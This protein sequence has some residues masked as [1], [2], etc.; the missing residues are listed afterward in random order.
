MKK[1]IQDNL[2]IFIFAICLLLLTLLMYLPSFRLNFSLIDDGLTIKYSRE[3]IHLLLRFNIS[4]VA[5]IIFEANNGRVR[6]AYWLVQLLI[7]SLSFYSPQIMHGFRLAVLFLSSYLIF[8]ILGKLGVS[9]RWKL[10]SLFLFVMNSGNFESFY[11]LGP[12]EVYLGIYFLLIINTVLKNKLG[13]FDYFLVLFSSFLGC[14]TK[15]TFFIVSLPLILFLLPTKTKF[16]KRNRRLFLFILLINLFLGLLVF[17]IKQNYGM[18]SGYSQN[19]VFTPVTVID[20]FENYFTQINHFQFPVIFILALY[21]AYRVFINLKKRFKRVESKDLILL[22]FI[23]ES[24]LNLAVLLPWRFVLGRYL[25]LVN[26]SLIFAFAIALENV[27]KLAKHKIII[28]PSKLTLLGNSFLVLLTPFIFIRN[29]FPIANL[30]LW[31]KTES[32]T[33]ISLLRSLATHIPINEEVFVNYAKGDAN[34]EVFLETGWHLEE[35]YNRRDIVFNYLDKSNLCADKERYIL[36]RTTERFMSEG[37][38]INNKNLLLIDSGRSTY[39]PINY[40]E[41]LKSFIR[42]KKSDL[43]SQEYKFDWFLYKQKSGTCLLV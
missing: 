42:V 36:D 29:I 11:R 31:Q 33:T 34:I 2:F 39:N 12:A 35:F 25:I 9:I 21:S 37:K 28:T 32:E 4:S 17:L 23:I 5:E 19:Y 24:V 41:V 8:S 13:R 16:V 6:P 15:E 40:G 18:V 27:W 30:Q 14:F 22:F 38:I 1:L 10:F 20:N 7:S 3:I 43:W 26:L